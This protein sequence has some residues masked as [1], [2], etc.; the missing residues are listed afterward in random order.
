[1]AITNRTAHIAGRSSLDAASQPMSRR[2]RVLIIEG[3]NNGGMWHYAF[4]LSKALAQADFQVA[5][6]TVFPCED[7]GDRGDVHL[8][9]ISTDAPP[10]AWQPARLARR[11][12]GHLV[13][14][15]NLHRIMAD[16]R[17]D[18]VHIHSPLGKLDFFYFKLLKAYTVRVIYTAH[19]ATPLDRSGDWFDWAR[20]R[21]ADAILV[22][23][24]RDMTA[25]VS[26]GI[27]KS[28]ITVIPH[29]N[30]LHFC[31]EL[32]LSQ[33]RAKYLLGLSPKAQAVLFFGTISPYKGLDLL[34]E[35]FARL[36]EDDSNPYLIIAGPPTEDF[37]PYR[38]L[39]RQLNLSDRV[40]T[41]LRYIPFAEFP[42]YFSACDLVAFPYRRISQSGV[43][44]LAYAY[45]KPVVVTNVGGLAEAV[46]EDRTGLI[47]TTPD[48]EG[49]SNAIHAGLADPEEAIRMGERGR[50]LTATKYS[51]SAIVKEIAQ[52]YQMGAPGVSS[53]D[54]SRATA[55]EVRGDS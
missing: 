47:A 48:P 50:L 9:A 10:S 21:A 33:D 34:I 40:I 38:R 39:I 20:Y 11:V 31:Q 19:D 24:R 17:P 28:K 46:A 32:D 2:V 12:A 45:A 22:H 37:A 5:L 16:F 30:Y 27:D 54:G 55:H 49:F 35:A 8:C 29:G 3:Q 25:L 52:V 44:Q 6:A 1:M 7:L 18:V 43:L 4:S 23:S 42:R 15:N 14:L 53:V 41:D 36:C 13:K 26:N 51:W